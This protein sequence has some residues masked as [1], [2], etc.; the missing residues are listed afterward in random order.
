MIFFNTENV[1]RYLFAM[2]LKIVV[3]SRD[4]LTEMLVKLPTTVKDLSSI[5]KVDELSKNLVEKTD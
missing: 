1:L 2:F 3:T 5:Q 4:N